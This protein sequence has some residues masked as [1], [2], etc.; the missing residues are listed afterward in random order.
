MANLRL[1][2]DT[3][4]YAALNV[5]AVIAQAT[6]G[7]WN[8]LAPRSANPPYVIFQAASKVEEYRFDGRG[9]TARYI[10]KA[11]SR[12]PWRKL[13][14]TVDTQIDAALQDATLTITGFTQLL[15]RRETDFYLAEEREGELWQHV[16]GVYQI[17]VD[18]T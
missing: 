3:A 5:A 12:E 7:V 18:Q 6:G 15:C 9:M 10:V 14:S 4:L 13:A 1:N 11:V 16:G 8:S 17:M 2:L